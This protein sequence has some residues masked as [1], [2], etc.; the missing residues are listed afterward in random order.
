MRLGSVFIVSGKS[1]ASTELDSPTAQYK[2][3]I[4]GI[5]LKQLAHVVLAQ[6][7][8]VI[9]KREQVTP[10]GAKGTVVRARQAWLWLR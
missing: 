4:G 5:V 8:I 6:S 3:S 7:A 9:G 2:I 10:S 1:V